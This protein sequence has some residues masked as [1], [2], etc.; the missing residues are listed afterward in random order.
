MRL[1]TKQHYHFG[2]NY[3]FAPAYSLTAERFVDLQSALAR[4]ASGLAFDIAQR[5][6]ASGAIT[7]RR[8][9]STP[10]DVTIQCPA[11]PITQLTI[12]A[13][14]PGRR[15]EDFVGE[16]ETVIEAVISTFGA[17]S[18]II[19]RDCTI[20]HLYSLSSGEE[21]S[22]RY[23]WERRLA[24]DASTLEALGRKILGGGLRLVM[25]PDPE[26]VDDATVELKVESFLENS[27][28][29]FVECGFVW[30]SPVPGEELAA[31]PMTSIV[32]AFIDEKAAPFIGFH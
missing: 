9:G 2:V 18:Q 4:P 17:P 1:D 29:L 8:T 13:A 12:V 28:L 11:A 32:E 30:S 22:F 19:R 6:P 27:R 7:L 3:L 5:I 15:L 20:R 21:H 24:Q 16:A 14:T 26:I 23:L 25:P 31:A 10:L